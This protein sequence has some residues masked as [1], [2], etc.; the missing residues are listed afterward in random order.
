MCIT[1]IALSS[2]TVNR[3]RK[4]KSS[5]DPNQFYH[6]DVVS[7]QF[8]STKML[9][10]MHQSR[11]HCDDDSA[12]FE[13]LPQEMYC[14]I[15]AYLGPTSSTLCSLVQVSRSHRDIMNTIGDVMLPV[16][17][18]R[19]R[20]PM[21]P[22]SECES[23]LSLFVR[24]ARIAKYVHDNLLPLESIL[25]K[26]FPTLETIEDASFSKSVSTVTSREVDHALDIALCLLGASYFNEQG[27]ETSFQAA[28]IAD[29]A[30]TTALEWRVSKLCAAFGAKAY[31]YAKV[32]MCDPGRGEL[33][34]D[35]LCVQVTDEYNEDE[36]DFSYGSANTEDEDITRLDKACMVIQLTIAKD[37][38]TS[39]Q[40]RLALDTNVSK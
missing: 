36:D 4:R 1:S 23:S 7:K 3:D 39:Q 8:I 37:I 22:K 13:S 6:R 19:F 15:V 9:N 2:R 35:S 32:V 34:F 18:S 29:S 40:V 17:K 30:S 27:S 33:N 20:K 11:M 26:D 24:H 38:K 28:K 16:A 10:T 14:F 12:S 31:K 25:E 21:P 5:S